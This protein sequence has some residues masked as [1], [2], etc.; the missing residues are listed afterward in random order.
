[1][2]VAAEAEKHGQRT[3]DH[4]VLRE[5]D[6]FEG[7]VQIE[8][9]YEPGPITADVASSSQSGPLGL[10]TVAKR[11]ALVLRSEQE[12]APGGDAKTRAASRPSAP[13]SAGTFPALQKKPC[14]S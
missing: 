8:V 5:V 12:V 7:A 10:W 13:A 3:P 9:L 14:W 11:A 2:R 4:Q 1:M 6:D